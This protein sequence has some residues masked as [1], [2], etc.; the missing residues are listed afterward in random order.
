MQLEKEI[1]KVNQLS[2]TQQR[3]NSN[4]AFFEK[5]VN[6]IRPNGKKIKTHSPILEITHQLLAHLIQVLRVSHLR[7][8]LMANSACWERLL[9][10]GC[11][12]PINDGIFCFAFTTVARCMK[13][14][15]LLHE[16]I[17]ESFEWWG[18]GLHPVYV[19]LVQWIE[20][21]LLFMAGVRC[22]SGRYRMIYGEAQL[23][24]WYTY[25]R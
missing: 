6:T 2:K 17:Q 24:P 12:Q 8:D 7:Q 20:I 11:R 25:L 3:Q 14:L 18:E 5:T 16:A 4:W 19:H 13:S 9:N 23:A 10:F 21:V 22:L 15:T 1:R